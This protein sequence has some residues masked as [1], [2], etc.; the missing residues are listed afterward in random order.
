DGRGRPSELD[1]GVRSDRPARV[2]HAALLVAFGL[3]VS[4]PAAHARLVVLTHGKV[5]RLAAKAD[6]EKSSGL[7]RFGAAPALAGAPDPSCPATSS[8]ELGLFTVAAN[9]V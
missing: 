2:K 6:P 1:P 4:A 5:L 7:V 9:A 3:L 8:F